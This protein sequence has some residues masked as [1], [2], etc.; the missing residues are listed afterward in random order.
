MK[1]TLG[2]CVVVLFA[3]ASSF[4]AVMPVNSSLA[5]HGYANS[6]AN[7]IEDSEYTTQTTAITG[8]SVEVF[9]QSFNGD[10]S[11][12]VQS[13][14]VA[15][16]TSPTAG[17]F[18]LT[19]RFNSDDLSAYS[20]SEL[21]TG[22]GGFQYTF[23]CEFAATVELIYDITRAGSFTYALVPG[24]S[25]SQP[26]QSVADGFTSRNSE[27]GSLSF[28]IAPNSTCTL[29]FF[30]V[31]NL[32]QNLPFFSNEMVATFSYTITEVPESSALGVMGLGFAFIRRTKRK[33]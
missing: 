13:I 4:A 10:L 32:H 28:A 26:N 19:T 33:G 22:G 1:S 16:W 17:Q 2:L 21:G 5:L 14:G 7:P 30:D 3:A 29:G 18:S 8:L 11:D 25:F 9:A 24:Y 12:S 23:T 6:G 31:S 15:N 27:S 20:G